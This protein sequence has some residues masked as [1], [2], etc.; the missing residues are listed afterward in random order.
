MD[1]ETFWRGGGTTT[2]KRRLPQPCGELYLGSV[3]TGTGWGG[4]CSASETPASLFPWAYN[5]PP[6]SSLGGGRETGWDWVA[7]SWF[8]MLPFA[9]WV[10]LGGFPG[11]CG[12]RSEPRAPGTGRNSRTAPPGGAGRARRPGVFMPQH[13]AWAEARYGRPQREGPLPLP[14]WGGPCK[15]LAR[16]NAWPSFWGASVLGH[17]RPFWAGGGIHPARSWGGVG[18]ARGKT[19]V[20]AAEAKA[21]LSPT[22]VSKLG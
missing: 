8:G 16:E 9:L 14:D 15:P 18:E 6:L 13:G 22:I 17:W 5:L 20:R 11:P 2:W 3:A 19:R 10:G 4:G 1:T 12:P 21:I 7:H